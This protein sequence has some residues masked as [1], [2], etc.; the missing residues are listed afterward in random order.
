MECPFVIGLSKLVPNAKYPEFQ[1]VV[2]GKDLNLPFAFE[3][4]LDDVIE[5]FWFL[6]FFPHFSKYHIIIKSMP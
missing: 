2:S 3:N 5:I 6:R 4:H 1:V